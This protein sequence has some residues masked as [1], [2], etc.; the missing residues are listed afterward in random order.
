MNAAEAIDSKSSVAV[1][2]DVRRS[3][4]VGFPGV[5]GRNVRCLSTEVA[6][7]VAASVAEDMD[8]MF[9]VVDVKLAL[10]TDSEAVA[11]LERWRNIPLLPY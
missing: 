1:S 7:G 10:G 5:W 2:V 6:P 8:S 4:S 9:G 3:A 11:A